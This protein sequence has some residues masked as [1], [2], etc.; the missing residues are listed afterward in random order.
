MTRDEEDCSMRAIE[1]CRTHFRKLGA[2][3]FAKRGARPEDI[4]IGAIYSAVDLAQ[5]HTG[6][7][8]SA[9]AWARQALDVMESQIAEGG[10]AVTLQ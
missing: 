1:F 4:A 8:T 10:D 5:H 3:E 7:T 2:V 9:I 6:D